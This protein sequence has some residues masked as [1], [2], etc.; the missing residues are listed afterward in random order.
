MAKIVD[1]SG[2]VRYNY[3]YAYLIIPQMTGSSESVFPFL[4]MKMELLL[5]NRF[6]GYFATTPLI[7]YYQ[8][9]TFNQP[10]TPELCNT[11]NRGYM[12]RSAYISAFITH[13]LLSSLTKVS[14]F[15]SHLLIHQKISHWQFLLI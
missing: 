3:L 7:I 11:V 1:T 10:D 15:Y 2:Q 14:C 6:F 9:G 12:M 8:Q 13:F 4:S 5:H